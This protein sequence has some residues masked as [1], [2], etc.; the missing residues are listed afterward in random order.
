MNKEQLS[1]KHSDI[2]KEILQEAIICQ[3]LQDP[4]RMVSVS[5]NMGPS[6]GAAL[7][8]M[9]LAFAIVSAEGEDGKMDLRYLL[10]IQSSLD[11][12]KDILAADLQ[13]CAIVAARDNPE[14]QSWL[15]DKGLDVVS[16]ILNKLGGGR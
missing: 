13:K 5:Q 8:V 4:K 2:A 11:K 1:A 3:D 6:R 9:S 12:F 15:K 7:F 14:F 16:D 10:E